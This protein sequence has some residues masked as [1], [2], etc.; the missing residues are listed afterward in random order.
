MDVILLKDIVIGGAAVLA[1][2]LAWWNWLQSPSKQNAEAIKVMLDK[3][4]EHDRRVQ[5]LETELKHLPSADTVHEL[6]LQFS[7]LQGT[8]GRMDEQ[9]GSVARTVHRIDDYLR[10]GDK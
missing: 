6:R 8:V 3:L 7:Q 2:G 1:A 9:I 5:T 10:R 4:T